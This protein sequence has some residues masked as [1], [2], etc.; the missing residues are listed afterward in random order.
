[1]KQKLEEENEA[2][3]LASKKNRKI[4]N[5]DIVRSDDSFRLVYKNSLK[6]NNYLEKKSNK[7]LNDIFNE[8][9]QLII[10]PF[11]ENMQ[12]KNEIWKAPPNQKNQLNILLTILN[13]K[14]MI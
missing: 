11:L 4:T 13:L 9:G 1:M 14:K 6:N 3:L 5:S 8:K 12:E 2:N 7:N 10:S